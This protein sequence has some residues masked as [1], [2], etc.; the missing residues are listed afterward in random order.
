MFTEV[1]SKVIR[2]GLTS[3][4]RGKCPFRAF[5]QSQILR[6]MQTFTVVD[7]SYILISY[8]TKLQC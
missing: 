4:V 1:A 3:N 6:T 5:E 8:E 7:V 2:I